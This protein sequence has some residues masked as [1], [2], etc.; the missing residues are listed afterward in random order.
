MEHYYISYTIEPMM[1]VLWKEGLDK[2]LY[3]VLFPI[4]TPLTPWMPQI[5]DSE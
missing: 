3:K 4:T 1:E 5:T 2:T